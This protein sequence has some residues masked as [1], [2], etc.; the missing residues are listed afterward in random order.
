MGSELGLRNGLKAV[1]KRFELC[2]ESEYDSLD[3]KLEP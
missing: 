2:W 3:A 1:E